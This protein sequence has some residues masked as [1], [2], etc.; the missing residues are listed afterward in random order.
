M[1]YRRYALYYTPA[2]TA[3]SHWAT[4][5]LGWDMAQGAPVTP[6]GGLEAGPHGWTETPRRYGLHA[7]LKPPFR[8]A[9]GESHESLQEAFHRFCDSSSPAPIGPVKLT[10]LGRFL[11]LMPAPQPDGLTGAA[12]GIV[13]AFDPFRAP[14][15]EDE[16][17]RRRAAG[18]SPAQEENLTQW[19]YPYVMDSFRF[20]IT[21]SEKLTKQDLEKAEGML[22]AHLTP[23][24]PERL[25][26]DAL[27]LA[28]EDDTGRFHLIERRQLA[29]G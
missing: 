8:L 13:R 24:L 6:P 21:L 17:T 19:G 26:L 28:G 23:L 18:L 27:S 1:T 4:R 20:H 25:E 3:W 2:A 29:G 11:A 22:T 14:A 12:A 7:T 16:L 9:Q 10:R 15:S 5:W